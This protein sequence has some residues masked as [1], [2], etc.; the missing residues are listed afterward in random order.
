MATMSPIDA[1]GTL[2]VA[3]LPT[4]AVAELEAEAANV[5]VVEDA[6]AL[7]AV[8]LVTTAIHQH[9][10]SLSQAAMGLVFELA[11]QLEIERTLVVEGS[12]EQPLKSIL[13]QHPV[14]IQAPT[15]DGTPE[16]MDTLQETI[17]QLQGLIDACATDYEYPADKY[18][19][20]APGFWTRPGCSQGG[21]LESEWKTATT[22]PEYQTM[23][24][25]VNS[26]VNPKDGLPLPSPACAR[27]V[28][29]AFHDALQQRMAYL[30]DEQLKASGVEGISVGP[31]T[32]TDSTEDEEYCTCIST[33][34]KGQPAPR[35]MANQCMEQAMVQ[36]A[37][38]YLTHN[39]NFSIPQWTASYNP[40]NNNFHRSGAVSSKDL[41]RYESPMQLISHRDQYMQLMVQALLAAK[42]YVIISTCYLFSHD[43]AQKYVLFDLLPY[44]AARG[45]KIFFMMDL[46][47][48]ESNILSSPFQVKNRPKKSHTPKEESAVEQGGG[49]VTETSFIDCLPPE[50]P[51]P[52]HAFDQFETTYHVFDQLLQM[53]LDDTNP[54]ELRFWCAR[55]AT[56]GYR[57]K[58]HSKGI[59]IDDQVAVFGGSNITPTVRTAIA[60]LDCF[61][62]GESA[63]AVADT[64][65]MLW[66]A[67]DPT[68]VRPILSPEQASNPALA[69]DR[70][71]VDET[72]KEPCSF[73]MLQSSPSS[74]GEDSIYRIVLEQFE[75]AQD[76]ITVSMGHSCFPMSFVEAMERAAARG[77]PKLQVMVNSYHSND[78]RT[79]LSDLFRSL[80]VLIERV[81]SVQVFATHCAAT[82][83][84]HDRPE[85]L[86]GKYV[87]VDGKWACLGSWNL[88]TRSSF[89]E[90][91]MEAFCDS[92]KVAAKLQAKFDKDRNANA[93]LVHLDDCIP[94]HKFCPKGC[95]LC[96]GF[97]NFFD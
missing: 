81:P 46:F 59:V 33:W 70:Y 58:N 77:V 66:H 24:C 82:A 54:F 53:S 95:Q 31:R 96:K 84:G 22:M 21:H 37:S 78:L 7:A 23:N 52:T 45:I 55:D 19:G 14:S 28:F 9:K 1:L 39:E 90:M 94:G 4:A 25:L 68:T 34:W 74:A 12:V 75:A 10:R 69:C 86:H 8:A 42:N 40:N 85:F 18:L 6:A 5:Q 91:E 17:D 87:V 2:P 73:S 71:I 83:S 72:M 36:E 67:V 48:F 35:V 38:D 57:I 92:P 15:A 88:W 79:G 47:V 76:S 26:K 20:R 51:A 30:C 50:A 65:W 27:Q 11:T 13:L 89:Y 62:F 44:L 29:V 64:F 43:V 41:P 32:G 49:G 3:T 63:K 80:R 61:V 93:V 16:D 97:G 56:S 60:D